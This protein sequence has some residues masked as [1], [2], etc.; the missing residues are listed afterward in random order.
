MFGGRSKKEIDV[1]L[2]VIK[3]LSMTKMHGTN[4]MTKVSLMEA[5]GDDIVYFVVHLLTWSFCLWFP[6]AA[7]GSWGGR[8]SV[9]V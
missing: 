2:C 5:V 4:F 7:R 1:L 6:G 8:Y 9:Q 3:A